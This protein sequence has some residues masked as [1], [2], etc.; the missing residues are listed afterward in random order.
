MEKEEKSL[1]QQIEELA[2]VLE[3]S[4]KDYS[5]SLKQGSALKVDDHMELAGKYLTDKAKKALSKKGA[6]LVEQYN[7]QVGEEVQISNT[8]NESTYIRKA[9]VCHFFACQVRKDKVEEGVKAIAE[10]VNELAEAGAIHSCLSPIS[11]LDLAVMM[12]KHPTAAVLCYV[13]IKPEFVEMARSMRLHTLE[14][15][16]GP[17]L[18]SLDIDLEPG[19]FLADCYLTHQLAMMSPQ[20][21]NEAKIY[22]R[23]NEYLKYLPA[24]TE[25]VGYRSCGIIDLSSPYELKFRNKLLPRVKRVSL[26]YVREVCPEGNKLHQFNLFLGIRYSGLDWKGTWTNNMYGENSPD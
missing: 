14:G 22:D 3:A 24:G 19:E 13:H 9:A 12:F 26:D 15:G 16:I 21:S 4:Q 23:V 25:F 17:E 5:K 2:K 8:K 20:K 18:H 7:E 6:N 11:A 10:T 1:K